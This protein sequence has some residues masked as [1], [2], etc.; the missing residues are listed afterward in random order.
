MAYLT[1]GAYSAGRVP[2]SLQPRSSEPIDIT[3]TLPIPP[4]PTTGGGAGGGPRYAEDAYGVSISGT[5]D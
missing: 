5:V 1:A 4:S 3:A 2:P